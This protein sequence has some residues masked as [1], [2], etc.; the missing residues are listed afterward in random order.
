[1]HALPGHLPRAAEQRR[2]KRPRG[3]ALRRLTA[4]GAIL[5]TNER[6]YTIVENATPDRLVLG[7]FAG[8]RGELR[9]GKNTAKRLTQQA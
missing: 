8:D 6:L 3:V 5:P 7:A 2:A 4:T 9:I 1:V